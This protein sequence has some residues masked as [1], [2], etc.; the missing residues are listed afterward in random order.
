[1]IPGRTN[2]L[3]LLSPLFSELVLIIPPP[4]LDTGENQVR[5]NSYFRFESAW[6]L[7]EG[8]REL[9]SQKMFPRDDIYILNY[10]NRKQSDLRRFLKGWGF[11]QNRENILTKQNLQSLLKDQDI[12]D[13]ERPLTVEEWEKRYS[14]EVDLKHI[15]EMEELFWHKKCGD[16][17]L[18]QGDRNTEFFHIMANGRKRRCTITALEINGQ[19]VPEKEI[20]TSH[21]LDYYKTLFRADDP[22]SIH[23]SPQIWSQS[24]CLTNDQRCHI[25]RPFS[26]D[27]LD[28][29]LKEAK[30]NTAPGPDG[31]NVH[32]YRAFWPKIRND[33]F[34][35]LLMLFEN[36]LDLK[37][38]NF[39]VISLIP[40]TSDP[41][42]IKQFKPICVLNDCFKFLNKVVT[43]R[44]TEVAHS[45][46][47]P[48]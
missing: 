13:D 28:K 42:N 17:E 8:F 34:E 35:M 18:L 6:L 12:H 36:K 5:R 7:K 22:P 20:L 15:Y 26:I 45:V 33:L 19:M 2:S 14:L 46:I 44:L 3:I 47:S 43:N 37:R 38:L 48:T 11:N 31:F 4:I 32:F 24:C 41:T 30:P 40:K 39:G 9:V 10:W 1:M 27:E 29:V 21:I 23:L 16:Q 25:I